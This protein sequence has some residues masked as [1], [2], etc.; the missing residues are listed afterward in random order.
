MQGSWRGK[1]RNAIHASGYVA[2]SLEASLWSVA[3]TGSF[4]RAVLLAANPGGGCGYDSSHHR[5]VGRRPL[6]RLGYSGKMAADGCVGARNYRYGN[7]VERLIAT[8]PV[9]EAAK[10]QPL[11]PKAWGGITAFK[12]WFLSCQ[13][14][15]NG[16]ES[17][18]C[19][20][21]RKA[22]LRARVKYHY[23]RGT[24]APLP[25]EKGSPEFWAAYV[26]AERL[27][28]RDVNSVGG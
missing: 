20:G 13:H 24:G 23:H 16:A 22:A 9:S 10:K 5:P 18:G 11:Q 15:G 1:P 28:P 3:R 14:S 27:A 25:G 2:H 8:F 26:D 17:G 4:D 6:W 12:A 7:G 21:V 19:T